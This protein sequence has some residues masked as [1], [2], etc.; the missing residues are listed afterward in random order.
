MIIFMYQNERTTLAAGQTN[1]SSLQ[2]LCIT[3]RHLS[4][5]DYMEQI[6]EIAKARP[7]AVIVREKDLP[8]AAYEQ[9]AAQVLAICTQYQVTCILHTYTETAV[10]L[11]VKKLHLPLQALL[12]LPKMC[13]QQF[14]TL[15]SSIHSVEEALQ[16]Q[17]AGATYLLAGHIFETGCKPGAPPRGLAFLKE[18]CQASALPVYALGGIDAANARACIQAGAKGVCV[19]SECMCYLHLS[20][21]FRSYF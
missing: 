10:R 11:G 12:S 4:V 18:V 19:M 15:G 17:H 21:R 6:R 2:I 16:A 8:Q 20:Q 5:Q 3:N 1:G 14:T 13:R 9:L 7:Q